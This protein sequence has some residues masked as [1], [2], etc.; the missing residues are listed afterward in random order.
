MVSL[1]DLSI[2][3]KAKIT[4]YAQGDLHFRR[5]LLS[6][7]LLPGTPIQVIGIA[8]LG[9]PIEISTRGHALCLRKKEATI[10]KLERIIE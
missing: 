9:D 7:G 6:M 10:L 2:G 8:P 1:G 5:K 3:D 4:G